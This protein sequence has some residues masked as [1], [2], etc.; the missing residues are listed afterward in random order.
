MKSKP[1][2]NVV[3][4]IYNS[5]PYL[6]E[7]IE[8]ILNQSYQP[9]EIIAIDD[10]STDDSA[11]IVKSYKEIRYFHQE[12]LGPA[13][14]R[15]KGIS[16]AQADYIGF[17]DADDICEKN[18]FECQM[19]L[20]LNNSQLKLVYSRIQNFAEKNANVPSFLQTPELMKPRMGFISSGVMHKTV[21]EQVGLFN[22]EIRIG[23]DVEW[24]IRANEKGICACTIPDVLIMRRLHENNISK[25]LS[26]GHRNLAR[27]L[28]AAIK[29]R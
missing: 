27:I 5:G 29:R 3:I 22:P 2:L 9:I 13:V 28:L 21:F 20:L 17:H 12:N 15:N 10:G 7:A 1:L 8:S 24:I 11:E 26:T 25:D 18:R 4:P 6:R 16:I 23:E 19:E 14:A